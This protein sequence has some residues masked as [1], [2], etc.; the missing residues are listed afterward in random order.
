LQ[1][2]DSENGGTPERFASTIIDR[3]NLIAPMS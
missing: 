3:D 1:T 2:V